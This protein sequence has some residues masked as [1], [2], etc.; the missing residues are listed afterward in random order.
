MPPIIFDVLDASG[1][2]IGQIKGGAAVQARIY[3]EGGEVFAPVPMQSQD[4]AGYEAA[5][6]QASAT[7]GEILLARAKSRRDA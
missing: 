1:G 2:R 4:Y 5:R 6:R 7:V 3:G